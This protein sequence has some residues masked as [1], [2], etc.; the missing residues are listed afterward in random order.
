MDKNGYK[1][2]VFRVFLLM[3][4]ERSVK[5]VREVHTVVHLLSVVGG[6]AISMKG[7]FM[8]A[9]AIFVYPAQ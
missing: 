4:G 6:S 3:M 7:L 5:V 9:Y 2:K 8:V 1:P